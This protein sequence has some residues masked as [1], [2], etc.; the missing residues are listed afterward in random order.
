M[1]HITQ[2]IKCKNEI[3]WEFEPLIPGRYCG[4][5][6]NC[7]PDEGGYVEPIDAVIIDGVE[8][9]SHCQEPLPNAESVY[10]E[11]VDLQHDNYEPPEDS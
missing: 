1:I 2:C 8:C 9:C 10:D 7:Y 5:P 6:E 4:L 3:E 11:F